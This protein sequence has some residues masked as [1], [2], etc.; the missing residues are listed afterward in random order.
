MDEFVKTLH[1]LLHAVTQKTCWA[2]NT[3]CSDTSTRI[4]HEASEC[5]PTF[6]C[7]EAFSLFAANHLTFEALEVLLFYVLN[8]MKHH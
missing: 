6:S 7:H 5:R 1:R 2:F 3:R 4:M 8:V